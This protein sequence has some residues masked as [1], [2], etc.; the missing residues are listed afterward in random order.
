MIGMNTTD[1]DA[2]TPFVPDKGGEA[3]VSNAT[4]D[5]GS[6]KPAPASCPQDSA[7]LGDDA[8]SLGSGG[9]KATKGSVPVPKGVLPRTWRR[10]CRF[11]DSL[12][13]SSGNTKH[14]QQYDSLLRAAS[15][16]IECAVATREV[17]RRIEQS[18]GLLLPNQLQRQAE[19]A[20]A[21]IT[22][23]Q[24][25]PGTIVG[26]SPKKTRPT[27]K[28]EALKGIAGKV[29]MEE[30]RGFL[31]LQS[32]IDPDTTTS[33]QFLDALF[34]KGEH[35]LVFTE[36]KSQGQVLYEAGSG[37]ALPAGGPDGVWFLSNPV[38]GQWHQNPRQG[39]KP[40][41]RSQ[42]AVTAFRHLL[43]E[44]DVASAD[45]WLRMLVQ[46]PL[47]MVAIYTSG[48]KSIHALV[49]VDAETKEAWDDLKAKIMPTLVGLG[50]DRGALT[51]VRLT[52]L[53][54]CWRGATRQELLYL[55][56]A[57]DGAPIFS[58]VETTG[59]C[60]A[61]FQQAAGCRKGASHA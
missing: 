16:G 55:N 57:A 60:P 1:L 56:P 50:A 11:M 2:N 21:Y 49:R 34:R 18:G 3:P 22:E 38:D 36:F 12:D 33:Q 7:P 5:E 29:S 48:G 23:S 32:K 37:A 10:F 46:I 26:K 14:N 58:P 47:P 19:R 61:V 43:I 45:D 41:R 35:V 17:A 59:P 25:S 42:E 6:S 27:F 28:P 54:Q 52:R 20:Y 44:S 39:E 15:L 4:P 24:H 40:S 9:K 13:W 53:P 8:Q 51:A 31:K 30:I